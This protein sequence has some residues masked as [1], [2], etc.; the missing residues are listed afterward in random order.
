MTRL[1]SRRDSRASGPLVLVAVA[2]LIA[3]ALLVGVV[4]PGAASVVPG[5]T[6]V[7]T[8][9][10]E[11]GEHPVSA[12]EAATRSAVLGPS[13]A[14]ASP[15]GPGS[16]RDAAASRTGATTAATQ[17]ED[18]DAIHLENGLSLTDDPGTVGVTTRAEIPDRVTELEV[19]LY[20]AT[21]APIDAE[22]FE[23]VDDAD[24]DGSVWAWDGRTDSPSLTYA[25]AAND[26]VENDD[27]GPIAAGGT[28]RFVDA[29]E[30]ALV[31]TPRT[32]AAWSYTG[33]FSG[34]VRLER[35]T[36]VDGEGVASQSMAFLGPYEERVHED[37][38]RL[39]I[40]ETADLT[41]DPDAV[42]SAFEGAETALGSDPAGGAVFAVA[43]P[44]GDVSWG[45]RGLQTGDADLWVRDG[46]PVDS[47]DDV[48]THEYVHTRQSYRAEASGAW[49][50]E[51]SATYYAA[52]FALD[53]GDVD[54]DDFERT[55]ARGEREPGASAVLADPSTW[56]GNAEYVKGALV[57]AEL[58]RRIRL[59]SDGSASLATVLRELN[60][61]P[62]P[63]ANRDVLGAVES[64]AA[65][66]GDEDAAA[67][68]R[69][70]AERLT[71]TSQTPTTWDR[72]AHAEA[73]GET[74]ARIG[75]GLDAD[76]VQATGAFRN[77]SVERDPVE[78]VANET[79]ALS[80]GVSNTGGSTGSYDLTLR[81]DGESVAERNGTVEPGGETAVRFERAFREPGEHEVRV[82]SETLSVVVTEPAPVLVRGVTADRDAVEAGESVRVTAT[83]GNDAAIPAE[84]VVEFV[85][86]GAVLATE[87]VRLDATAET[88]VSRDLALD[89]SGGSGPVTVR[90]V[91]PVDEASATVDVA[92]GVPLGGVTDGEVPGFGPAT[93]LVAV[94]SA[95]AVLASGVPSVRNGRRRE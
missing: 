44:T 7:S 11:R 83:V 9:G 63:I 67:E 60:D 94:L 18:T 40:P 70:T 52:L 78:L 43:A 12:A 16:P 14:V 84:G 91:G 88:T 30:W 4:V 47:A 95:L 85:A 53:R 71:S 50:T 92:G 54:F 5:A 29:G 10:P 33:R 2:S 22:G 58:D 64:A 55:L 51:G 45:V 27:G 17:T 34:Q 79:L 89:A 62:E 46:E 19:T 38:Y 61:A 3:V 1:L 77:R 26:T 13:D 69:A 25:M 93:A 74:P 73:F 72:A 56:S 66:G 8:A 48:W 21:D 87:R 42:F 76:G 57:A 32:A 35:E 75:Y 20:S 68:V 81:V 37:R 41:V 90:V 36:V 86:D 80:V 28:Y 31:Q 65:S 15:R 6:D 23:R 82:G 24:R 59:A 39:I 49:F